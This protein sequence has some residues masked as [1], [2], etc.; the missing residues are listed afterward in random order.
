MDVKY[1]KGIGEKRAG[2]LGKLGLFTCG[3]LVE[4]YP[5]AYEDRTVYKKLSELEPGNAVCV[6]A[7]VAQPVTHSFVRQG[8][9]LYKTAVFDESGMMRLTFFNAPYV[10]DSL[11]QG[12]SYVFF[13]RVTGTALSPELNNPVFEPEG[14]QGRVT[15]RILPKYP[16]TAGCPQSLLRNAVEQALEKL[17]D[18]MPDTLPED[19]RRERGL[20]HL[21]F[22]ARNIHFPQTWD[23]LEVARRRLVFEELLT[24]QLGLVRLK[25]RSL[26]A[27]GRRLQKVDLSDFYSLLGFEL[28]DGQKA[29]IADAE[30]DMCSGRLMGRLVQGDVGSGKTAVAAACAL[31][32]IRGGCQVALMAPTEI[33]AEQHAQSLA[34]LMTRLGVD[35]RLLTGRMTAAQKKAVRLSLASGEAGLCIGT[36]ALL[37]EGVGFQ[38]L[39]LI[40]MDEQ[41]R[42]GVRQRAGLSEKSEG[43]PPHRLILSATPIPRTLSLTL[44]GDLDVTVMRGLPPGRKPVKTYVVDEAYRV[45]IENFV[46]K[47]VGLGRQV[48]CIC[49]L[50]DEPADEFADPS[51]PT[52]AAAVDKY[53]RRLREE[54]FPELRVGLVHGR[55]KGKDKEAAMRSFARGETDILVATTVIEVGVDV[56]NASLII[57]E[58]AERFG[59]SQLHQLR[60]RVGRGVHE[61][62]C[63]LFLQTSN[64]TSEKRMEIMRSSND[65]FA[66]AE[67]DLDLRG[68]GDFFGDRQHGLPVFKLA[69]LSGDTGLVREARETAASILASDPELS[70]PAHRALAGRVDRLMENMGRD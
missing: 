20:C 36:H 29:A 12:E 40:I 37:S 17:P 1:L 41:H 14:K 44:F 7:T 61:S 64:E 45:R 11:I 65:G 39:G 49:P 31:M 18:S 50:I 48:Y 15:G 47:Q 59:L 46:R 9:D 58:N 42:F 27:G 70:L 35:V 28:T 67:A 10:Q 62:Y 13:G 22:A 25:S 16:S 23:A 60:G 4:Y 19:V 24:L 21:G 32:A 34:P 66:I 57:V 63:V 56:P 53:A 69:D 30:R 2:L 33:L 68:P 26:R 5:R 51:A 55:M 52:G 38:D 54:V 8:L 6:R 43:P 3:D